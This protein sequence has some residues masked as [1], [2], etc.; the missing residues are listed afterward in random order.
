MLT[1]TVAVA[2]VIG[3][4]CGDEE[5]PEVVAPGL[6]EALPEADYE[7]S[8]TLVDLAARSDR[9]VL[10]AIV[11]VEEG[12][13]YGDSP[14]DP[15]ASRMIELIVESGEMD[16]PIHLNW[17]YPMGY[18]IDDIKNAVPIAS[19]V[20]LYLTDFRTVAEEPGWFHLGEGEHTHWVLTTPQGIILADA[21]DGTPILGDPSAPFRDAPPADAEFPEWVVDTAPLNG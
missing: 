8:P 15:E 20:V 18:E 6:F 16:G 2:A 1:S 14:T 13:R 4:A 5:E 17:P 19:R 21:E 7:P 3:A 11:D 9:V 12:W 10:G